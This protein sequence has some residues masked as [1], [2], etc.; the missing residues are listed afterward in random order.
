M[1][2]SN[3]IYQL[4]ISLKGAE[5][6]IWRRVLIPEVCS[7]DN[8]HPIIQETMGWESAHLHEFRVGS[9]RYGATEIIGAEHTVHDERD[10]SLADIL[11]EPNDRLDY[12]YDFGDRWEHEIL[13]EDIIK[14]DDALDSPVCIEGARAC[15]PEDVGGLPGYELFLQ[16]IADP[17][18]PDHERMVAWGGADFDPE[19]FDLYVVNSRL[20]SIFNP[21][22]EQDLLNQP[23]SATTLDE[24]TTDAPTPGKGDD[25]PVIPSPLRDDI[26]LRKMGR[27]INSL[28]TSSIEEIEAAVEARLAEADLHELFPNT[29]EEDALELVAQAEETFSDEVAIS[30]VQEALKID[31]NCVDAYRVLADT[32]PEL[33]KSLELLERARRIA[34]ENLGPEVFEQHM[35]RFWETLKTRPYMRVRHALAQQ[36][37]AAGQQHE[38]IDQAQE[39]LGLNE[40]DPMGIRYFLINWLLVAKNLAGAER[41][42]AHFPNT[43]ES[44]GWLYPKAL[45]LFQRDGASP[46]ANQAFKDAFESNPFV[47]DVM[48][49]PEKSAPD[50]VDKR[51]YSE[52]EWYVIVGN[53]AWDTTE[54]AYEWLAQQVKSII[55]GALGPMNKVGRNEPC[56]CGSGKKYKRCCGAAV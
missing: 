48:A 20:A 35:G 34:E 11:K 26:T 46:Q 53:Q 6:P 36:L 25:L 47:V 22:L 15:P 31:P 50:A 10:F 12:I 55:T 30:L 23:N 52:A 56:P 29:P 24:I 28:G 1:S 40:K 39:I 33:A 19:A 17:N 14:Q 37:W 41:L 32:E 3:G 9:E 16:A 5:P 38:A 44:C 51:A 54:G 18:H 49:W 45:Y 43:D 21:A 42:F 8:L 27:L 13:L 4:K 2:E 7:L